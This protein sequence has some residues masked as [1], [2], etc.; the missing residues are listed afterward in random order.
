MNKKGWHYP[1]SRFITLWE[2]VVPTVANE[3][4]PEPFFIRTATNDATVLWHTNL[5]PNYYEVDDFQVRTPTDVIGQHIHLV[6]FDVTS[7]DG[8]ANGF[9]YEDGTFGPTEVRD[10][11]HAITNVGGLFGFDPRTGF[12]D[13][14][15]QKD[16]AVWPN[17]YAYPK[18][19]NPAMTR[20]VS[21]ARRPPHQ[22]W[23]GAM[24]TIQRWA[25]DPLLNWQGHDRTLRTVFT[26]DHFGPSTHQ[27]VGLYAGVLVEP[28][29]SQWYLPDGVPMYTRTDGG[30]TS[31]QAMIVTANPKA[32]H[33]EYAIEFQDMQ[34]AYTADS[35]VP[36]EGSNALFKPKLL[37]AEANQKIKD[38]F[39]NYKIENYNGATSQAPSAF[40]IGQLQESVPFVIRL[41]QT[42]H[43]GDS[44]P[45][46]FLANKYFQ[47]YGIPLDKNT[48]VYNLA[49][50]NPLPG[51][52][53]S[54]MVVC[55]SARYG[56]QRWPVLNGGDYYIL[57]A[58][59]PKVQQTV[60]NIVGQ[61]TSPQSLSVYTPNIPPGFSDPAHAVNPIPEMSWQP[62]HPKRCPLKPQLSRIPISATVPLIHRW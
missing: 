36:P 4:A 15:V 45:D 18:R 39:K 20:T 47:N 8:G 1:Q 31:W 56:R 30:P 62:R 23:E 37:S 13:K 19:S 16:V 12:V 60:G 10:R 38:I 51:F 7:S 55:G 61:A 44:V 46:Q 41:L 48:K 5:V 11:I 53:R 32:S 40:F 28:Q 27:Q 25:I 42:T 29:G 35:K 34:L 58:N 2:D 22:N 17:K 59:N 43:D 33:R 57:E 52:S 14:N 9:N 21:S 3:R 26:H 50:G 54:A 49:T 24:T 6:K